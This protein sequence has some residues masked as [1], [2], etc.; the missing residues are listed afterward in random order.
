MATEVEEQRCGD[1]GE[2]TG[3]RER[4][5]RNGMEWMR[6]HVEEGRDGRWR[7]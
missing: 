1:Q 3:W 5:V 4:V 7:E 2:V 6:Q